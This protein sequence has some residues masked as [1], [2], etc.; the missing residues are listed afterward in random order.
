MYWTNVQ[1]KFFRKTLIEGCSL[2]LYASFGNFCV[3]IGQFF[4]RIPKSTTFD[5]F[6]RKRCQKKR[7]DVDYNL[8]LDFFQKYFVV[9]EQ[10]AVK[11]TFSTYVC[12]APDVFFG[13]ICNVELLYAERSPRQ[14]LLSN[15]F[16]F[17]LGKILQ[18]FLRCY[19]YIMKNYCMLKK[20][21]DLLEESS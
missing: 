1:Q 12:Y 14:V 20:L 21:K 19:N 8:L 2:H 3:Q 6:G 4:E 7:K 17:F 16:W 13:W 10:S 15:C 9:H 5:Q 18:L 11:N